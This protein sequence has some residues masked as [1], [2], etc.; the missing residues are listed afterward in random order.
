V[1]AVNYARVSTGEQDTANQVDQLT[2][3]AESRGWEIIE[4]YREK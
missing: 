4:T 2:A 1:K 3:W